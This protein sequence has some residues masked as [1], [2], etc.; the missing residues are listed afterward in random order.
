[1]RIFLLTVILLPVFPL[2]ADVVYNYDFQTLP[3]DW[4]A[5]PQWSF[6]STG[7]EATV[8]AS[9]GPP[10]SNSAVMESDSEPIVL[11]AGTDSVLIQVSE[12]HVLDGYFTTGEAYASVYGWVYHNG[13]SQTIF[14][15]SQSWGFPYRSFGGTS[16]ISFPAEGGDYL[17]FKFRTS[18]SAYGGYAISTLLSTQ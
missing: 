6:G 9:G 2:M 4:T 16:S 14:S 15:F 12:D 17:A 5:D 10:V 11:P 8:S 1:M 3:D 13:S 7:A 18:A